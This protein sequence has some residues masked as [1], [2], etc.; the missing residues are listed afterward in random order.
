M[1]AVST[2]PAQA[3]QVSALQAE[4]AQIS[5][6]I[7]LEQLQIGGYQQQYTVATEKAAN[8]AVQLQATRGKVAAIERR[9]A[10]DT[11]QV[12]QEAIAAYVEAGNG[13]GDLTT[14]FAQGSSDQLAGEEYRSVAIGDIA[15]TLD[16]LHN[17]Q[18]ALATQ[19]AAEQ[20]VAAADQ[21][22]Q[23]QAGQ[24]LQQAN[25]TQQALQ[26]QQAQV[27]GQLAAAVAQQQAEEAAAAQAA[28]RAA[29]AQ[30]AAKAAP[31]PTETVVSTPS[32]P[33]NAAS[34]PTPTST[35]S[36]PPTT[37]GVPVAAA[38][39]TP[40]PTPAP[41]PT[42]AP[43][44]PVASGADPALNPFLQCVIQ[45]ESSGNYQAV[46]PTGEYMGAFQFSQA[47]WN[48]AALLAGRPDLVGVPPTQASPADQDELAVALYNA[49]GSQPWYDPCTGH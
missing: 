36:S 32:A 33:S 1:L 38:A 7:L 41:A 9:V 23:A 20:K 5:Q 35:P 28:I 47:T 14:L 31:A 37:A 8:D 2:G 40:A 24:L 15:T 25:D 6:Q 43:S 46:S 19:E 21:A 39:P 12:R 29:E 34:S 27:T 49:D 45:A 10:R 17:D 30:A 4:A 22:A 3:D 42:A 26:G 16:Q 11:R 48:E 44:A 18:A 13:G